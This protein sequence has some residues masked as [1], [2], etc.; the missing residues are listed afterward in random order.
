MVQASKHTHA[1][2]QWSHVS[3][4]LTQAHPNYLLNMCG[5]NSSVS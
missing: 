4:G 1:Q 3:V 5:W 2:V